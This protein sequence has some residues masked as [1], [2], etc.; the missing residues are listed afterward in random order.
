MK[1]AI[2]PTAPP[3]DRL[4]AQ[5]PRLSQRIRR[6]AGDFWCN[7]LFWH[8]QHLPWITRKSK[9]FYL[10]FMWRFAKLTR[11]AVMANTRWLLGPSASQAD[12][13]ALA[14]R[15]I[16]AFYDFVYDIGLCLRCSPQ[17]LA[18]QIDGVT[19][20]DTYVAARALKRGAIVVTAHM[21]SFEAGVSALRE[22]EEKIHVVFQ[23]DRIARFERMRSTLRSRLGV[24]EA[25]VDDGWTIWMRLR[26]ALQNDEVVMLQG[27]RVMPGQK[28]ARVPF[29]GG[30]IMLPPG[31]VKLA[32]AS[33]APIIPVFSLRTP[34][35]KIRVVVE[36]PIFVDPDDTGADIH[37]ALLKIAAV[38]EK[39]VKQYPD[40]WIVI[41]RAWC[42]DLI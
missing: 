42:E 2:S 6:R 8:S 27:D 31:P 33:G 41:H 15:I 37:P 7:V 14:R 21:G 10:W 26:D 20:H 24:I 23:R 18:A 9:S 40:Q 38:I 39:Y 34:E 12:R 30:H 13:E 32:L 29:C 35:G 36:Q 5:A 25:P 1:A 4:P 22:H 11:D 19:N 3:V 28:G 16:G 17:Q